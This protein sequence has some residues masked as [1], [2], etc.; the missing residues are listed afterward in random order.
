M[1]NLTD[2]QRTKIEMERLIWERDREKS[3]QVNNFINNSLNLAS[4]A[5][6]IYQGAKQI[7]DTRENA[8]ADRAYN[9]AR[10]YV[11]NKM[12][13]DMTARSDFGEK[14]YRDEISNY[15][16]FSI[17]AIQE[18]QLSDGAKQKLTSLWG[19]NKPQLLNLYDTSLY[20][21]EMVGTANEVNKTSQLI[22][23]DNTRYN[24]G[25]AIE[26]F[27]DY[28]RRI[29]PKNIP[30][31]GE[32]NPLLYDDNISL[33][34]GGILANCLN[35]KRQ[36]I[37]YDP[38][39]A[40]DSIIAEKE[41]SLIQLLYDTNTR[42]DYDPN[43]KN[44]GEDTDKAI[45]KSRDIATAYDYLQKLKNDKNQQQAIMREA[46]KRWKEKNDTDTANFN[47][48]LT[49]NAENINQQI[50]TWE[51]QNRGQ[52]YTFDIT[53]NEDGTYKQDSLN[54]QKGITQLLVGIDN[55]SNYTDLQKDTYKQSVLNT[56]RELLNPYLT[57]SILNS[58]S[59]DEILAKASANNTDRIKVSQVGQM[60]L[61]DTDIEYRMNELVK[62][63]ENKGIDISTQDGKLQLSKLY[64]ELSNYTDPNLGKI[65]DLRKARHWMQRDEYIQTVNYYGLD[66]NTKQQLI[67]EFDK[68]KTKMGKILYDKCD[69]YIKKDLLESVLASDTSKEKLGLNDKSKELPIGLQNEIWDAY[70]RFL[71]NKGENWDYAD[72]G[73][74]NNFFSEINKAVVQ[75]ADSDVAN[76]FNNIITSD[77]MDGKLDNESSYNFLKN[78]ND[79]LLF[80]NGFNNVYN[81]LV[82]AKDKKVGFSAPTDDG[83]LNTDLFRDTIAKEYFNKENYDSLTWWE[84][85]Q[86]MGGIEKYRG[87]ET[88]H[89]QIDKSFKDNNLSNLSVIG[90]TQDRTGT[91]RFIIRDDKQEKDDGVVMLL[92]PT[93]INKNIFGGYSEQTTENSKYINN[94][95]ISS[96]EIKN[97][98]QQERTTLAYNP[99]TKKY[100]YVT[101]T[102]KKD[103]TTDYFNIS[104]AKVNKG[105]IDWNSVSD[106]NWTNG[107]YDTI[108]IARANNEASH[109]DAS[110]INKTQSN[111]TKINFWKRAY[112][113]AKGIY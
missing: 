89:R 11:Q 32:V 109:E 107:V 42:K 14:S 24:L 113:Q 112:K 6:G 91:I 76:A 102:P 108:K 101:K 37:G 25:E 63:A 64:T 86:A 67:D 88:I 85:V 71:Q 52:S 12:S 45:R 94:E 13:T 110:N 59:Y 18:M 77:L 82:G 98:T 31:K 65:F 30:L 106:K 51:L 93:M 97:L 95:E 47:N 50:Q 73:E 70:Y 27:N 38:S 10:G 35:L 53:L 55:N 2:S 75:Y 87:I 62:I 54:I 58:N 34:G 100:H 105:E 48:L 111:Y 69:N 21:Y 57:A 19:Q 40:L 26:N 23:N 22:Y 49:Q 7:K 8:E 90:T 16:I 29:N 44:K 17:Q 66:P 15:N 79:N 1:A 83:L 84:K 28:Y 78:S 96:E 20:N 103:Y 4:T 5:I 72:E 43:S 99:N 74:I 80:S 3:E 56:Y 46:D 41:E 60:L 39:T 33:I 68:D 104:F 92:T 81:F 61:A 36:E 9:I